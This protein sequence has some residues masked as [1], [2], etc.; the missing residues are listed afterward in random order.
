MRKYRA[1]VTVP[2]LAVLAAAPV[3]GL[4]ASVLTSEPVSAT[5][6]C[7]GSINGILAEAGSGQV[8]KVD[9]AYST[10]LE[11][12]VVDQGG[13]PVTGAD[14]EFSVTDSGASA[15][16][17]GDV[18]TVTVPT[19]SNGIATAPTLTANE[20]SG[21]F[22]VEASI[23]NYSVGFQLTNTTVG[24]VS[25][26]TASSGSGQAAAI[27]GTFIEP[28]QVAVV[29]SYGDPIGGTT[30][31]FTVVTDAGAGATFAGGGAS[32]AAQTNGNGVAVSPTLTAG[33]TAGA[34]TVTA[35][36]SGTTSMATFS[37]TDMAGAPNAIAAG[38][39]SSQSTELGADFAV[40]LA[41]TVTDADSNPIQ[42][43]VVVFTAPGSG[44]SGVFAG[45][46]T[47]AVVLANADGVATAPD[48]SANDH[49]GG[50]VVTA[51]VT[52]LAMPA[53]F[54]LVNEPRSGASAPGPN[55]SYWLVT[56]TGQ[57]LRSGGAPSYGSIAAKK[58]ASPVVGIAATPDE[59]GYWLVTSKGAVYAFGHA[60]NYGSPAKIHLAKPIV[61][62][63]STPDGKGYWLVAS[64]GGIFNYG[65]AKS[66]GSPAKLHLA[67]PIVGIASTP[68]GKG[69]WLVASDGGIF[70][71]GD[72]KSYGSPA[73]LHLAKP[74]VGIASTPDGKGY[75]LL[76]ANGTIRGYG[77]G[78]NYGSGT[79]VSPQPVRAL[80]RTADGAGYWVVS[81]NGTA[82]G[83]GDAGA[84]GSG[85]SAAKTVVAGAA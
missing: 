14:V 6:T 28:L 82:A 7:T 20:V 84:Q 65:D 68:D 35:T 73:K 16:F 40:P 3:L 50:Y 52:G 79:G 70:T 81:A 26:I 19:G 77:D 12:E 33:D 56:S 83:F 25:S 69:Y 29:D 46:G 67:K 15:F 55:G 37:L 5:P 51:K 80:V 22:T 78:T 30:V 59:G 49:T 2:A 63:A 38:V 71:Y 21:S 74:I 54:A 9:T 4:G 47:T 11:A 44:A 8:A 72:A 39:G 43:A 32:A 85:L 1:L 61:G 66:Y 53:T 36:V 24:A 27:G 17:P 76:S 57:V 64:D 62:I 60:V 34:F 18:I 41:V 45:S 75:W 48:F 23:S 42:G 10:P 58:L 31:D 13:C